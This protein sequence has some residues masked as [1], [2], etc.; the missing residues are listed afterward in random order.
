MQTCLSFIG[1]GGLNCISLAANCCCNN[2]STS[3]STIVGGGGN[4]IISQHCGSSCCDGKLAIFSSIGGGTGNAI[5]SSY[6]TI[7]GGSDNKVFADYGYIPGGRLSTI[8]SGHTGSAILG[9]G[10]NRAHSS[11]G[12]HTLTL[13]F[14]SGTYIKNKAFI[15]N[16]SY[17]PSSYTSFGVSG[18]LTFDN[19]YFYR[20]N[21]TN[22]TRT[23][24]SIW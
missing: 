16:D 17:I 14:I 21:G 13:D 10:Q 4:S 19:N 8:I 2:V 7:G 3:F 23:A 11:S 24:L 1:G 18:Q 5:N 6:S 12:P 22:W 20:H 15:Q 9:D